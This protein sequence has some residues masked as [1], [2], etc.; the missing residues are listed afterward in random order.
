MQATHVIRAIVV[1]ASA[2]AAPA[3]GDPAPRIPLCE[4]MTLVTAVNSGSGDYE[5]IKTV[6]SVTAT[7]AHQAR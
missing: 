3:Q 1:T 2:A 4:G 6:K 7:E 5:S